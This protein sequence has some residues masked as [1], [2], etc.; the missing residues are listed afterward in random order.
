MKDRD[1]PTDFFA[2][3]ENKENLTNTDEVKIDGNMTEIEEESVKLLRGIKVL[4]VNALRHYEHPTHQT[5]EKACEFSKRIAE[6][7]GRGTI[8]TYLIHMSHHMGCHADED[9]MLPKDVH[10]AYDGLVL[11]I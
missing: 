3:L 6:L 7:N 1:L 9:A 4:I 11:T 8:P 5:V 2:K 10:L